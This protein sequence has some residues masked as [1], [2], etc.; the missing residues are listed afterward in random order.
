MSK[1]KEL[2]GILKEMSSG[3]KTKRNEAREEKKKGNG[4][5][6]HNIRIGTIPDGYKFR[7]YHIAYCELRGKSREQIEIPREGNEPNEKWIKRI[8]EEF[9]WTP[10]EIEAFN[11]RK[12]RNETLRV[13]QA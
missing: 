11:Q 2:K 3:I 4:V 7:I 10:E 5:L 1:I 12:A 13:N 6:S 8:K 9:A